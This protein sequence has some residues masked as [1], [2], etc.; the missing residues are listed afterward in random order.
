MDLEE[1]NTGYLMH[2][3]IDLSLIGGMDRPP[4]FAF[5]A[6]QVPG[7]SNS[8]R[9]WDDPSSIQVQTSGKLVDLCRLICCQVYK[10]ELGYACQAG[11]L[12]LLEVRTTK[13]L[14]FSTA[15]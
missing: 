1:C 2:D 8:T 3:A 9:T 10:Y 6:A 7:W 5:P 12:L 15:L 14:A 11:C 4:D 13:L